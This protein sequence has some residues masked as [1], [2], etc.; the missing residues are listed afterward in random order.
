MALTVAVKETMWLQF[1][2]IEQGVLGQSKHFAK[3]LIKLITKLQKRW[4][5]IQ[6]NIIEQST[7]ISSFTM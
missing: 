7:L 2:F 4:L 1:L 3:I 5:K 6:F